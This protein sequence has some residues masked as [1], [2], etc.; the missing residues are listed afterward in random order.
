[1]SESW[2]PVQCSRALE[3]IGALPP[4]VASTRRTPGAYGCLGENVH[5]RPILPAKSTCVPPH[6][7]RLQ[8][9][10][11]NGDA[12]RTT[13]AVLLHRTDAWRRSVNGVVDISSSLGSSP[14][15]LSRKRSCHASSR[16]PRQQLI[17]APLRW[18]PSTIGSLNRQSRL[19]A[20][21]EPRL[22][23]PE[24]HSSPRGIEALCTICVAVLANGRMATHNH[25]VRRSMCC[26]WL[27]LPHTSVGLSI[28]LRTAA[29]LRSLDL[30]SVTSY[31]SQV[32]RRPSYGDDSHPD[33][34]SLSSRPR[35]RTACG[36][37]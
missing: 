22:G 18:V 34:A 3:I 5:L 35:H 33:T 9:S 15:R 32:K 14:C 24:V 23:G 2:E 10:S 12:T 7:S 28:K 4:P 29:Q 19:G 25:D 13:I 17:E 30:A 21:S 8:P 31:H 1:M 16:G 26:L 6:S 36:R 20:S 11:A 37:E 27:R